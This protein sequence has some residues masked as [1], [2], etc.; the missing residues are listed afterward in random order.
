M[1]GQLIPTV[2]LTSSAAQH[3]GLGRRLM[4]RAEEI[5]I[6]AGFERAAVIAG[7]GSRNYYRRLGY[8]VEGEGGFMVKALGEGCRDGASS[9]EATTA[10]G[11]REALLLGEGASVVS[12]A[13]SISA[14][15]SGRGLVALAA[16]AE[17]A[18]ADAR[19]GLD[20][21]R[22]EKPGKLLRSG[23]STESRR[24][25][26][27]PAPPAPP[28]PSTRVHPRGLSSLSR[29]AGRF[30]RAH[31]T[32]VATAAATCVFVAGASWALGMG[33]P[34]SSAGGGTRTTNR[35]L[36]VSWRTAAAA[37]AAFA[38]TAFAAADGRGRRS[39]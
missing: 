10:S 29:V 31:P 24:P 16:E 15:G 14:S 13:R 25:P 3:A 1:Y 37:G 9:S 35:P 39:N 23:S 4:A 30:C 33:W 21:S 27:P 28:P 2:D 36:A 38:A 8:E 20:R 32:G 19:G 7:I 17:A 34:A 11:G 18:E 6:S 26:P 22:D 5:A 12:S